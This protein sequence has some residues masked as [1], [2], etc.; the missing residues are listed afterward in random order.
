MKLA[1]AF[2]KG[3]VLRR[4][5]AREVLI[6]RDRIYQSV[7]LH[8]RLGSSV[9]T[10]FWNKPKDYELKNSERMSK[11]VDIVTPHWHLQ[12]HFQEGIL[13]S[14]HQFKLPLLN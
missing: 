9:K 5:N 10:C 6:L 8:M 11:R 2:Q 4:V 1:L 12:F 3:Q 13:R 7:L 14:G